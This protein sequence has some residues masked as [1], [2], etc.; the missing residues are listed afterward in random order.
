MP[1]A[2]ANFRDWKHS[3]QNTGRP[4]VGLN[5]TVVS[6]PQAE[7]LVVVSTRSLATGPA[8]GR[9]ARFAL[10]PLHRFG[11]FFKFLSAKKSCSPAVQMNSVP[12]STQVSV[13]SR[14]S[15][16]HSLST[17]PLARVVVRAR[18]WPGPSLRTIFFLFA[19]N[20]LDFPTLFLARSLAGERLLG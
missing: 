15:L 13:L 10:Q 2:P 9:D 14:N 18:R 6:L 16:A 5:G 3:L 7:Q 20:L 8:A 17:I 11:S 4:C 19:A 1:P 12:Q